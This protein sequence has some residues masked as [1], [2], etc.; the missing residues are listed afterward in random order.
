LQ[1][2]VCMNVARAK[3]ECFVSEAYRV[4]DFVRLGLIS[5]ATAAD[6][7]HVAATYNQLIYE[8]GVDCIQEAISRAFESEAA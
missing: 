2:E 7:L 6:Y 3:L 8:Y 4:A 1:T 5:R